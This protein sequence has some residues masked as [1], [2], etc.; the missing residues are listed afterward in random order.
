MK[1]AIIGCGITGSYLGWK[2]AGQGHDVYIIERRK[3]IGKPV[4]S[5]MFSERLWDFVPENEK[6]VEHK[7][8]SCRIHFSHK[9]VTLKFEPHFLLMSHA[10]LDRYVAK[11]AQDAG[12]K[13]LLGAKLE[14]FSAYDRVIGCD[15]ALSETRKSL[16]IKSPKLYQAIQITVSKEAKENYVETWPTPNGFIWKIPRGKCIEYGI[17]DLPGVANKLFDE[18]CA[19]HYLS[20]ENL[21]AWVI[22]N[23][24][25]LPSNEKITLCGDAAGMTKPWSGGGV[26]WSLHAADIL[27]K[28]F[29]DFK[30]YKRE[31]EKFFNPIISRANFMRKLVYIFGQNF[32]FLF[33]KE[34]TVDADWLTS[35]T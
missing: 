31:A 30:A 12:A 27:L 28:T 25:T 1:I 6:L 2:L 15:G 26:L 13:I 29:P 4:C 3:E 33:P 14:D 20:K 5:G 9:S 23:G 21:K 35:R 11:L 17:M 22:P 10:E 16:N 19:K 34:K 8:D 24:L 32:S 18:F 7:I